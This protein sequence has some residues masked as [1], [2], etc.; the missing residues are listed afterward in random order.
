MDEV[1]LSIEGNVIDV[2]IFEPSGEKGSPA[3]QSC[4]HPPVGSLA[5]CAA[6]S[7][8]MPDLPLRTW[9]QA[10]ALCRGWLMTAQDHHVPL[11]DFVFQI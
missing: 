3:A 8:R 6:H 10:H 7:F 1:A 11:S 9:T 2:T 4:L 5:L